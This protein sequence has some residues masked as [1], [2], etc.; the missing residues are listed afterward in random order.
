MSTPINDGG[1]AFPCAK[2]AET[3]GG[4]LFFTASP[5]MTLRAWL[6][7][8]AMAGLLADHKYHSDERAD[9]ETGQQKVA[10]LAVEHADCLIAALNQ[11]IS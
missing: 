8:Q 10:R 4:T 9:G 3:M 11:P 6:A 2:K 7:G 5:G 1:P